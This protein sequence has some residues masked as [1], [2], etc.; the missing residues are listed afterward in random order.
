MQQSW[1]QGLGLLQQIGNKN[2]ELRGMEHCVG[3]A[4][5]LAGRVYLTKT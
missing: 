5:V 4:T 1:F 3:F 2:S